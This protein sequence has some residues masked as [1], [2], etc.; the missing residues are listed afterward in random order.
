MEINIEKINKLSRELKN[1]NKIIALCH[2]SF[3]I[4]HKG[5]LNLFKK[6]KDLGDVLF[7][8]IET[9]EYIRNKK[10]KNRP[11]NNLETRINNLLKI[12]LIDYLFV[13]PFDKTYKIYRNIYK[14]LKPD[15][16]V[17][18]KDERLK[19]KEMDAIAENIKMVA[20][21]DKNISS[22]DFV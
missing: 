5:H 9:N 1:D 14:D 19:N 11:I 12:D 16:L 17:T 20:I 8:G 13:I 7:V 22:S 15:V 6:S 21:E 18:A 10:G 2:G 3:D 4:L